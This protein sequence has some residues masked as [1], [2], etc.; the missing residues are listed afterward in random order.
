M[1]HKSQPAN[2]FFGAEKGQLEGIYGT[3]IRCVI[4]VP[5]CYLHVCIS[6]GIN[7]SL[8]SRVRNLLLVKISNPEPIF[9]ILIPFSYTRVCTK[10]TVSSKKFLFFLVIFEK[11]LCNRIVCHSVPVWGRQNLVERQIDAT[12]SSLPVLISLRTFL[13]ALLRVRSPPHPRIS[14]QKDIAK[15]ISLG[16]I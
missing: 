10:A 2:T 12:Y 5:A 8:N 4:S 9:N 11:L 1:A 16:W 13:W 14:P 3:I 6:S 15:Q 7:I